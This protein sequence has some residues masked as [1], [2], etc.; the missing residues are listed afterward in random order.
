MPASALVEEI[1][2]YGDP[3]QQEAQQAQRFTFISTDES[4]DVDPALYP[5]RT[6][7]VGGTA[8][9]VER[10]FKFHVVELNEVSEI[11]NFR[12]FVEANP[13]TQGI[14]LYMGTT[15][16]YSAPTATPR[17]PELADTLVPVGDP[18]TAN[19]TIGGS[20]SGTITTDDSWTDFVVLQLRLDDT[21]TSGLPPNTVI[22]FAWDEV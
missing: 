3:M 22:W 16:T 10:W 4:T 1:V 13:L 5:I 6:P 15:D 2:F 14:S 8:R 18:G 20:L 7:S 21:V 11:S 19:V 17:D 9:S 12:V